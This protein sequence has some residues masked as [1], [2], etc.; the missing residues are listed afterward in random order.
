MVTKKPTLKCKIDYKNKTYDCG[1]KKKG[2]F[3]RNK[4]GEL[5]A[6]EYRE[7]EGGTKNGNV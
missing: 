7:L 5:E 1:G 2:K 3:I 4:K 6:K